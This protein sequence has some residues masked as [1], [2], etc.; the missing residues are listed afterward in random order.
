MNVALVIFGL[1]TLLCSWK[2]ANWVDIEAEARTVEPPEPY[3]QPPP[4][5]SFI[6]LYN[7]KYA[8]ILAAAETPEEEEIIRQMEL[9]GMLL[10]GA[11][12]EMIAQHKER[13]AME[14]SGVIETNTGDIRT[15]H[16]G[17]SPPV[18]AGQSCMGE[19]RSV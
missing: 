7:V 13:L 4:L 5:P 3:P 9:R 14:R 1:A 18:Y 12:M 6:E 8:E 15:S 2:F 16:P 11:T 17:D 19:A 10:S